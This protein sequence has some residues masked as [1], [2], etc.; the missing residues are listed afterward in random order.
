MWLD[1]ARQSVVTKLWRCVSCICCTCGASAPQDRTN[2]LIFR[3]SR[4]SISEFKM[5]VLLR[6]D[7]EVFLTIGMLWGNSALSCT[8]PVLMETRV[9]SWVH[10]NS[11]AKGDVH[12]LQPWQPWCLFWNKVE[13]CWYLLCSLCLVW[14]PPESQDYL[15]SRSTIKG[16]RKAG[17][18]PARKLW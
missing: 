7:S 8:F 12:M 17:L 14:W 16:N 9:L 11:L 4:L 13:W 5:L 6:F 10:S 18:V 2:G 1:L 15:N 3:E